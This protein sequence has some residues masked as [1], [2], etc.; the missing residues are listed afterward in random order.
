MLN[1][2]WSVR[3]PRLSTGIMAGNNKD[4]IKGIHRWTRG[5]S[6]NTTD[7]VALGGQE[8]GQRIWKGHVSTLKTWK[9]PPEGSNGSSPQGFMVVICVLL[10]H[11]T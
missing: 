1:S 2:F 6:E 11:I 7:E 4:T 3:G 9:N 5:R 10:Y 8:K